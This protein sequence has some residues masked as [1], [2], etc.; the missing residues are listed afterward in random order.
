M[1]DEITFTKTKANGTVVKKKV[2]V[3]RD[4]DWKAWLIWVLNLQE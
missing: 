3:F 1:T 4:G 2:P